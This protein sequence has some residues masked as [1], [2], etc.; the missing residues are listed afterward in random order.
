MVPAQIFCP[1][2][3]SSMIGVTFAKVDDSF[4]KALVYICPHNFSSTDLQ[5]SNFRI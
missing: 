1:L 3:K 2:L 5:Y 4:H